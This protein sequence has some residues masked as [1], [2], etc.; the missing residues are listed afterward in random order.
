M[1]GKGHANDGLKK[2]WASLR[3]ISRGAWL[4]KSFKTDPAAK[5]GRAHHWQPLPGKCVANSTL[6]ASITP[7]Q[8]FSQN[9]IVSD[10]I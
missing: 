5:M 8:S 9:T 4:L 2:Q 10:V 6:L 7:S 3:A 1:N